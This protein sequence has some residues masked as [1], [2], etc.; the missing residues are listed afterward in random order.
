M[1]QA[2]PLIA[3]LE[4]AL[5]GGAGLQRFDVLRRITDLFLANAPAYAAEHVA[6]FDDVMEALIAKIQHEALVELS[7]RLAPVDN[8]PRKVVTQLSRHDD[9]AVSGPV[10]AQSPVLSD[11]DLADVARTKSQAHLEAIAGRARISAVITDILVDRGNLEVA[12]KV[13]DNKG[14]GFSRFGHAKLMMR[15]EQDEQL[16]LV[17]AKRSDLPPEMFAQLVG[18]AAK[19]VQE[20]MLASADPAMHDRIVRT[21]TTVSQRVALT[22]RPR[23]KAA[24]AAGGPRVAAKHDAMQLRTQVAQAASLC[25]PAETIDALAL[26]SGVPLRAVKHIVQQQADDGIIILGKAGGLGW[27]DLKN[28]LIATMPEKIKKPEDSKV[29]FEKFVSLSSENAQR[30]LRFIKTSEAA[31]VG[32]IRKMM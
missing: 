30:V 19:S 16:A 28:V 27:P 13:T 21:L 15:A 3:E 11:A 25:K 4:T 23:P 26:L 9:I 22:E 2:Q 18:R 32:D 14:A 24:P 29:L 31:S 1:A 10:L 7:G 17:L 12:R 8:A 20:K 6:V 5:S